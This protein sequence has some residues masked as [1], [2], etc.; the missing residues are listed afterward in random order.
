MTTATGFLE[1]E[2]KLSAGPD[3]ASGTP[4]RRAR[5]RRAS[6]RP[7]TTT[8]RM[9]LLARVG[10]YAAP[11]D[12]ARRRAAGSSSFRAAEGGSSSRRSAAR[13][14][15]AALRR[16]PGTGAARAHALARCR[17]A[18]R[19]TRR[20]DAGGRLDRR[21]RDR[22]GRRHGQPARRLHVRRGRDRAGGRGARRTRTRSRTRFDAPE[23]RTVTRRPKAPACARAGRRPPKP[24]RPQLQAFFRRQYEQILAHDPGNPPRATI[25]RISTISGSRCGGSARS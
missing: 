18:N 25:R 10:H 5:C 16:A 6:S 14:S 2:V 3:L 23:P 1:R 22:R 15:P 19:P 13:A 7:S 20:E 11:Q 12:R 24:S 4:R 9:R 17:A 21:C 8:P